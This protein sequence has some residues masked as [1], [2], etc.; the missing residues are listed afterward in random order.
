MER[1]S[2]FVGGDV[3]RYLRATE[4]ERENALRWNWVHGSNR[5]TSILMK[6]AAKREF[7]LGGTIYNPRGF[8]I[9]DAVAKSAGKDLRRIYERTQAEFRRK[10]VKTLRVYRGTKKEIGVHGDVESWTTDKAVAR[11]F[12]G[13]VET[14][15]IPIEKVLTHEGS[16]DWVNG[17]WGNQKEVVV[18]E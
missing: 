12:G 18:L 11:K 3:N 4:I 9:P 14:R 5:K 16:A 7:G 10:G 8:V 2:R 15:D 6:Q 13:V 17:T 1:D